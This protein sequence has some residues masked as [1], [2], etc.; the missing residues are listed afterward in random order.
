MDKETV[1]LISSTAVGSMRDA[2]SILGKVLSIGVSDYEQ[3]RQVLGVVDSKNIHSFVSNVLN[4][5]RKDALDVLGEVHGGGVDLDNFCSSTIQYLRYILLSTISTD[6]VKKS[7]SNI[8]SEEQ[9]QIIE[10][11]SLS[12][13][14]QLFLFIREMLDASQVIKYSQ[15][16]IL[17]L[18]L[19]VM[20]MTENK[21]DFVVQGADIEAEAKPEKKVATKK[22]AIK[23][24][25]T[26]K[27]TKK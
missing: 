13:K 12:S 27:T 21:D 22:T 17:S 6:V 16:P 5:N 9:E 24:P 10:L 19:V 26:K 20:K 11:A 2:Q 4:L 14:K 18:E 8:S 1:K 7:F 3:V 15:I 23:K 25:T